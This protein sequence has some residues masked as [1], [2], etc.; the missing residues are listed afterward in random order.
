PERKFAKLEYV[1]PAAYRRF[2]FGYDRARPADGLTK[3][4]DE[5]WYVQQLRKDELTELMKAGRI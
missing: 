3:C 4:K 2:S 5:V 1:N